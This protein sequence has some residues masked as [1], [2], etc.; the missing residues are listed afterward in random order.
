[1]TAFQDLGI[2][3][4]NPNDTDMVHKIAVTMLDTRVVP[5]FSLDPFSNL[6]ALKSNSVTHM[7]PD[8][9]FL[10]RTVQM[11]RGIAYAFDLNFSLADHWAPLAQRVIEKDRLNKTQGTPLW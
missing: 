10:V 3:M 8:L 11:M 7:P 1:M 4:V 6:E 5:G 2:K 9:Y